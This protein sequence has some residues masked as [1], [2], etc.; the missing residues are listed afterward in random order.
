MQQIHIE[1]EDRTRVV[2]TAEKILLNPVVK[3]DEFK[4]RVGSLKDNDREDILQKDTSLLQLKLDP[5]HIHILIN[6]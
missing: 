5:K 1:E 4:Q 6:V 2:E 3:I